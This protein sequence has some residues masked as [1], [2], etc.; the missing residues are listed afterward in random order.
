[1][2]FFF[3]NA[4]SSIFC[5]PEEVG[6]TAE[7]LERSLSLPMLLQP[8]LAWLPL[9]LSPSLHAGSHETKIY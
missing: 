3:F 2:F 6:A 7:L 5:Q 9:A 4:G 1:M 8:P